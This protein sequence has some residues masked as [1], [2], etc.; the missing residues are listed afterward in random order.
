[1]LHFSNYTNN[2]ICCSILNKLILQISPLVIIQD[3]A[4]RKSIDVY[5][6]SFYKGGE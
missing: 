4:Q 5:G 1:M 3:D 6:V 2:E